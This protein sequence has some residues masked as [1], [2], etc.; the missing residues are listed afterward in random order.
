MLQ[1]EYGSEPCPRC[2]HSRSDSV[3]PTYSRILALLRL[4]QRRPFCG[5]EDEYMNAI[6]PSGFCGCTDKFHSTI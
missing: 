1:T 4:P 5:Y 2:S 6:A 3:F